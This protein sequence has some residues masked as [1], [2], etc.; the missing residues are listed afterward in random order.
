MHFMAAGFTGFWA[1]A[2]AGAD[3]P[4]PVPADRWDIERAYSPDA[5]SS[6]MTMYVRCAAFCDGVALFDAGA[7][8][9]PRNEAVALDPQQRLLMEEV[10]SALAHAASATGQPLSSFTGTL[11]SPRR[12]NVRRLCSLP[13]TLAQGVRLMQ[14]RC[15]G[16]QGMNSTVYQ[17]STFQSP[18]VLLGAQTVA[19]VPTCD[20]RCEQGENAFLVWCRH[21]CGLHVPRIH[22]CHGGGCQEAAAPGCGGL[23]PQLHGWAPVVHLRPHRTLHLH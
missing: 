10:G 9:L 19:S 1:S 23:G 15:Q 8:R 16:R 14:A 22:G 2:A 6:A 18:V 11:A 17:T 3:L 20:N 21:L 4:A 5:S 12:S 13:E 7:F